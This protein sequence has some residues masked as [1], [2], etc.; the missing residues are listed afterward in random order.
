MYY[1]FDSQSFPFSLF[2]AVQPFTIKI[3]TSKQKAITTQN[4]ITQS[5][6]FFIFSFKKGQPQ[7]A[8]EIFLRLLAFLLEN[9]H[10]HKVEVSASNNWQFPWRSI[11]FI[12]AFA[13]NHTT[14]TLVS[15]II[16]HH[17]SLHKCTYKRRQPKFF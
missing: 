16:T 17:H 3:R 1:R 9:H 10:I 8:W 7:G 2:C 14:D 12:C 5:T 4:F 13:G 11:I 6:I 15:K